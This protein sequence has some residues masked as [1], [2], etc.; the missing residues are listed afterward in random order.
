MAG[1]TNEA[2][3]TMVSAIADVNGLEIAYDTS[4]HASD[5]PVVLVMGLGAQ[6]ISWPDEFCEDLV[7]S[8]RFVVR[9]DN[10]DAGQSTHLDEFGDPS[11]L[12]LLSCGE[13]RISSMTWPLTRSG[14]STRSASATSTSWVRRLAG[15]SP[16]PSRSD[17]R[18][19]CAR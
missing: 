6:R 10:R 7:A 13:R 19:G 12:D 8:G 16:R 11:A 15:S 1:R 4:G 2:V 18:T 17:I 9:F 14:S 5:P 3:P